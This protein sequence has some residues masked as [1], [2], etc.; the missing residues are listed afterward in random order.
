MPCSHSARRRA[1]MRPSS[2]GRASMATLRPDG[3]GPIRAHCRISTP[4][5]VGSTSNA[6]VAPTPSPA[7]TFHPSALCRRHRRPRRPRIRS[8][9]R[10]TPR[11][12]CGRGNARRHRPGHGHRAIRTDRSSGREQRR[13]SHMSVKPVPRRRERHMPPSER[14]LLWAG[15]GTAPTQRVT[16]QYVKVG[17]V[18]E[19]RLPGGAQFAHDAERRLGVDDLGARGAGYDALTALAYLAAGDVYDPSG[20]LCGATGFTQSGLAGPCRR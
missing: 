11:D 14:P 1:T 12:G 8:P 18:V 4:S 7:S 16:L 10:P 20:N 2:S 17:V 6:H 9:R 5:R 13:G 15:L 19:P 3:A